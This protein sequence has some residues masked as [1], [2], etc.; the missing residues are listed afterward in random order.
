[1]RAREMHN[2]LD[3]LS[4]PFED[5]EYTCPDISLLSPEDQDWVHEMFAKIRADEDGIENCISPAEARKLS[6]LLAG[7]P[8]LDQCEGFKGP[9]LEIP[10]ELKYY[11]ELLKWHEEG[12]HHWPRVDFYKLKA[13]QKVRF[14][15]LWQGELPRDRSRENT[16]L[17]RRGIPGLLP[18]SQWDPEDEAELRSLLEEAEKSSG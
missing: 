16:A 15:E 12:R 5:D 4:V 13:V 9:D 3:K 1:M 7:L 18:L 11:F 2:K 6:D 17:G 8:V 14:V 10:N